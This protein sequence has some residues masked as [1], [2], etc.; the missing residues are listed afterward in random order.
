MYGEFTAASRCRGAVLLRSR[1]RRLRGTE[2]KEYES[3]ESSSEQ[4]KQNLQFRPG[5][6][7]RRALHTRHVVTCTVRADAGGALIS[8]VI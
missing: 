8:V 5:A 2:C 6:P 3:S 1:L 4:S 7:T